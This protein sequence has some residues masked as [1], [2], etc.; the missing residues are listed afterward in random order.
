MKNWKKKYK[1]K[2]N[3]FLNKYEAYRNDNITFP[4]YYTDIF[5]IMLVQYSL[6][7]KNGHL[8]LPEDRKEEEEE[9]WFLDFLS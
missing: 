2:Y 6:I 4:T 9:Q 5:Y 7:D 1:D 3:I 8:V